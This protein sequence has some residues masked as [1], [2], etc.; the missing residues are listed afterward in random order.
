MLNIEILIDGYLYTVIA[1]VLFNFITVVI[2]VM[3]INPVGIND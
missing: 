3:V 1:K 2:I